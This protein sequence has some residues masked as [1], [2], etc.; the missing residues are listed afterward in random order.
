MT[1][2][3]N[4]NSEL[5]RQLKKVAGQLVLQRKVDSENKVT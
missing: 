4:V 5:E 1:I 3:L 2:H